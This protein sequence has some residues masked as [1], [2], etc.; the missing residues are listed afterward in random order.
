MPSPR[1]LALVALLATVLVSAPAAAQ[2]AAAGDGDGEAAATEEPSRAAGEE[3][4]G[5][6]DDPA[7]YPPSSVRWKL[8]AG[9]V[10]LTAAA[11]GIGA[12]CAA[13][14]P[15]VPGSDAL[16]IPVAGPWITL[17]QSGCSPDDPGCEAIV[18]VRGILLVLDGLVQAG[19]LAVAGEGLFMTTESET[20]RAPAPP[21]PRRATAV[22]V[23]PVPMVTDRQTGL[24]VVGSF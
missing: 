18:V 16:Y 1:T 23:T 20:G 7:R 24:G 15:E 5:D 12:A 6:G 3:A 8:V 19:G 14:W 17:G 21:A 2:V 9:G 4:L 13:A 11:Y 22:T 10:G